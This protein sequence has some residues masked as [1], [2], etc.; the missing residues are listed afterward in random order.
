[1][2]TVKKNMN[3][4]EPNTPTSTGSTANLNFAQM[5]QPKNSMVFQS[6]R[7]AKMN[8]D[9]GASLDQTSPKNP[10]LSESGVHRI[11]KKANSL[12]PEFKH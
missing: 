4:E 11:F 6:I 5:Y 1:M 12:T 9:S 10:Q 3:F 7:T 2:S 8:L